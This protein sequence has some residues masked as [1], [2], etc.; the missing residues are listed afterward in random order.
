MRVLKSLVL[1]GQ[2]YAPAQSI[3]AAGAAGVRAEIKR[4]IDCPVLDESRRLREWLQQ[5][6]CGALAASAESDR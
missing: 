1:M 5:L 2:R 6:R 3:H 4:G